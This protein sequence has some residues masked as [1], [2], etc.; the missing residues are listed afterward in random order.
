MGGVGGAR[1]GGARR[2]GGGRVCPRRAHV[3][4]GCPARGG[5]ASAGR[6]TD[7]RLRS[8][9][10]ARRR[11]L[12]VARGVAGRAVLF[13]GADHRHERVAV[14]ASAVAAAAGAAGGTARGGQDRSGAGAGGRAAHTGD[15]GE[16]VGAHRD[17]GS[18]G[19]GGAHR[20]R[21]F[22][23]SRRTPGAGHARR[24]LAVAGRGESGQPIGAGGPERGVGSSAIGVGA[25]VGRGGVRGARF[26]AAG[27]AESGQQRLGPPPT[28]AQLSEPL[29]E[30]ALCGADRR[31]L[32]AHSGGGIPGGGGGATGVPV[33][34]GAAVV[35]APEPARAASL[36]DAAAAVSRQQR[37]RLGVDDGGGCGGCEP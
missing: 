6:A 18:G 16:P 5:S 24:Q 10:A 9:Y 33:A 32:R 36:G 31:R 23:F 13:P 2:R 27:G 1:Y 4:V 25:R 15:P 29:R 37:V 22:H 26:P 14:A 8:G 34:G 35:S 11:C 12:S 3:C 30:R 20:R 19:R 28:A 17:G 7:R 21:P